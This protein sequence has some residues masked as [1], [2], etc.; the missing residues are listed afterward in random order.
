MYA[1]SIFFPCCVLI[2]WKGT[3]GMVH[4]SHGIIGIFLLDA[5]CPNLECR[6]E[7]QCGPSSF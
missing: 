7:G 1:M 2:L 6:H 4:K 5:S 3:Y